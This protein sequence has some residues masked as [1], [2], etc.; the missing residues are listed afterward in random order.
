MLHSITRASSCIIDYSD[1]DISIM[2]LGLELRRS[3]MSFFFFLRKDC[4]FL[5]NE[6]IYL[7]NHYRLGLC[8]HYKKIILIW[9][10]FR[11]TKVTK[12]D[13]LVSLQSYLFQKAE[14]YKREERIT[15]NGGL[16]YRCFFSELVPPSCL[17]FEVRLYFFF[18]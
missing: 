4:T 17:P 2:G 9:V 11:I 16:F 6:S 8:F 18:F 14:R 3:L 1:A 15:T 5:L 12:E 10:I 7:L 13:K